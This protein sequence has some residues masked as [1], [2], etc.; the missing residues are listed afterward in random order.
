M[1]KKQSGAEPHTCPARVLENMAR[2]WA[3]RMLVKL[4]A[5]Q[6][7]STLCSDETFKWL[8]MREFIEDA[9]ARRVLK[10]RCAQR[11]REVERSRPNLPAGFEDALGRLAESIGLDR[12]ERQILGFAVVLHSHRALDDVADE[13]G[14]LSTPAVCASLADLLRL[15]VQ[16]VRA[17]LSRSG[18]LN[19]AGL[20]SL[21]GGSHLRSCLQ[22]F[23]GL[24]SLLM[25]ARDGAGHI[26]S[27]FFRP[28]PESQL[29]MKDYTH[30]GED[31][32]ILTSYLRTATSR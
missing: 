12:T 17:A 5:W 6:S 23:D 9:P 10:A 7:L 13:L 1:A 30:L 8:G 26:L 16:D 3:L 22:L 28:A 4:G 32:R 25:D 20:L 24:P 14:I 11:L 2:F 15:P 19:R 29:H 21:Y 31:A 18:L 27:A